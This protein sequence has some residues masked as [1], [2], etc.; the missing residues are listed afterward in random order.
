[1]VCCVTIRS[2]VGC[3]WGRYSTATMGND[4]LTV[5]CDDSWRS[6]ARFLSLLTRTVKMR[7]LSFVEHTAAVI[8]TV[9]TRQ[10]S[11]L[12]NE[13]LIEEYSIFFP[14]CIGQLLSLLL[15]LFFLYYSNGTNITENELNLIIP[16]VD[17]RIKY[18]LFFFS[19]VVFT[20]FRISIVFS[21]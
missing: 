1:M 13:F 18:F 4:N 14:A 17:C 3:K 11:Q 12:V 21:L 7:R 20:I 5:D 10:N 2:A 16:F 19:F 8:F 6:V 15:N 9:H